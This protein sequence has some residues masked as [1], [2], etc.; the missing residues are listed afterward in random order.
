MRV[1]ALPHFQ[2]A[3]KLAGI[4]QTIVLVVS[5]ARVDVSAVLYREKSCW[6]ILDMTWR[7]V[8]VLLAVGLAIRADCCAFALI[9][10]QFRRASFWPP[11][12]T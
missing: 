8:I 2:S 1:E 10:G 7:R 6:V 11:L 3:W 12:R 9:D 4:R 5:G